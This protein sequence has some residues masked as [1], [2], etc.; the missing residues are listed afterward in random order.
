MYGEN[1]LSPIFNFFF[2]F[3]EGKKLGSF[4]NAQF[5]IYFCSAA[6]AKKVVKNGPFLADFFGFSGITLD[7]DNVWGKN[8]AKPP[9]PLFRTD[10]ERISEIEDLKIFLCFWVTKFS[11]IF[12]G[13]DLGKSFQ[14]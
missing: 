1:F 6:M 4:A 5:R 9:P 12:F 14:K 3:F 2:Y 11:K 10:F 8:A 7:R 13:S